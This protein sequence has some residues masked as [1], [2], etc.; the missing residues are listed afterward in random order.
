MSE[1]SLRITV[2]RLLSLK[3]QLIY[4]IGDLVDRRSDDKMVRVSGDSGLWQ[5]LPSFW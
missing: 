4:F 2:A 1:N 5:A 3:D